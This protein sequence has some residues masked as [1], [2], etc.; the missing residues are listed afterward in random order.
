MFEVALLYPFL[1]YH[2]RLALMQSAPLARYSSSST[3][4]TATTHMRCHN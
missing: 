2:P 1:G 3:P 4:Q